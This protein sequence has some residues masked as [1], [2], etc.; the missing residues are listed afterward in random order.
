M[1]SKTP[2]EDSEITSRVT[3]SGGTPPARRSVERGNEDVSRNLPVRRADERGE[4]SGGDERWLKTARGEIKYKGQ[5]E[6]NEPEGW[7]FSRQQIF[8][9][10]NRVLGGSR[11]ARLTL[12]RYCVE[13]SQP[14][15]MVLA[16]GIAVPPSLLALAGASPDIENGLETRYQKSQLYKTDRPTKEPSVTSHPLRQSQP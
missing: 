2:K 10:S 3:V 5:Q 16:L 1:I 14:G 6:Q 15:V 8:E 12:T 13:V 4:R 11:C 7:R 9:V